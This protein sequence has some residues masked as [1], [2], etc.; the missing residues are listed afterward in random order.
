MSEFLTS[1]AL[2]GKIREIVGGNNVKCAVAYWGDHGF[3]D[4]D[5]WKII[6]DIVCGSTSDEVL[7]KLG[8]PG[9][10]NLKHIEK[11]HAKVYLSDRGVVIGSANASAGGLDSDGRPARLVEAGAFH[12]VNGKVWQ[13]ATDWFD[14]QFGDASVVDDAALEIAKLA[15]RPSH[16]P[17]VEP[18]D[19]LDL[20]RLRPERFSDNE[21]SFV[22]C[23]GGL[24]QEDYEDALRD[25]AA[26]EEGEDLVEQ[27]RDWNKNRRFINFDLGAIRS[28]LVIIY[29]GP[30][31]GSD[32]YKQECGPV[33][34]SID[35]DTTVFLT[36]CSSRQTAFKEALGGINLKLS[37]Q[38]WELI[39]DIV[40]CRER[41]VFHDEDDVFG[42]VISANDLASVLER[43]M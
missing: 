9:N 30:Q 27:Y 33:L 20:V 21:I 26:D 41:R 23:G 4:V 37:K 35:G 1:E 12:E 42:L 2:T 8:A 14:T 24:K 32:A 39:R 3:E 16:R 5:N 36:K 31:G 7:K 10:P 22:F 11:L 38:R 15:Y 25:S 18:K 28:F 29:L 34:R 6:C 13:Q 40:F 43:H 17:I 19:F